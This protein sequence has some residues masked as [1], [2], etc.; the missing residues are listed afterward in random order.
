MKKKCD[1]EQTNKTS[2][3]YRSC[4]TS[5]HTATHTNTHILCQRKI[6]FSLLHGVWDDKFCTLYRITFLTVGLMSKCWISALP[7][8]LWL[9]PPLCVHVCVRVSVCICVH[10]C[11]MPVKHNLI[12]CSSLGRMSRPR[13]VGCQFTA[14][15]Q[16]FFWVCVVNSLHA[17]SNICTP[18]I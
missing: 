18:I 7:Y 17:W 16:S 5:P 4:N 10:L 14:P 13:C 8:W 12:S 6:I 2:C 1:R 15:N 3:C 9:F 11:D